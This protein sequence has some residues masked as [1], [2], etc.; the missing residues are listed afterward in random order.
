MSHD[1][2]QHRDETVTWTPNGGPKASVPSPRLPPRW[3]A[4]RR[5]GVGGQAEVWEAEDRELRERVA[6]KVFR[7]ELSGQAR[8]RLR[9]EV[10]LGR[11]LVHPGLV[12]VFELIEVGPSLAVAMELVGDGESVA[13]VLER[14]G[15]L[16][17]G[18][19]VEIARQVLETLSYVHA[20][21]V[22]HRDVKPSNLLV[23]G[24]GRVRL[25]DLGLARRLE[26]E[27]EV[28]RTAMAVGTPH[29]M[30][31]EQV[32]G[33]RATAATDLYALGVTLY[34]MVTGRTP[35][36]SDSAFEVASQHLKARPEDPRR[37]RADCP[38]WLARFVLRLLEKRPEDRYA[39]AGSALAALER[40][41][42]RRSP[43]G[44][45]RLAMMATTVVVLAGVTLS[46]RVASQRLRR[47]DSVRVEAVGNS[48]QGLDERGR[49]T[50]RVD[51]PGSLVRLDEFDLDGDGIDEYVAVS[52]SPATDARRDTTVEIVVLQRDGAVVSRVRVVD[53]LQSWPFP[54]PRSMTATVDAVDLGSDGELELVARLS[55]DSFYPATV[56]VFWPRERVWE[57][58]LHNS[59]RITHVAA[60]PGVE[61]PLLRIAGVN[62]RLGMLPF[63][64]EVALHRPGSLESRRRLDVLFSPD[65]GLLEAAG[66][67]W[68][69]Y[70]LLPEGQVPLSLEIGGDLSSTVSV[71]GWS[72]RLDRWGNPAPG[73]NQ[74]L[75]LADERRA[76]SDGLHHLKLENQ[77]LT[78]QG[79]RMRV[80]EVRSAAPR[81]LR[82]P[83]F[84]AVLGLLAARALARVGD[85]PGAIE[86]LET[87][88]SHAPLEDIAYRAAHFD[89][90]AGNLE[91]AVAR[92]ERII[93]APRTFRRFDALLLLVELA[94]AQRDEARLTTALRVLVPG[95]RTGWREDVV[96][97]ALRARAHLWWDQAVQ[98]DTA[99]VSS[100]FAP[101]GEAIACLARWRLGRSLP[102]DV[103]AM[104]RFVDGNPD[105]AWAGRLALAAAE[106]GAG[107][108]VAAAE[109]LG[110]AVA[111]LEPVSRDDFANRQLL[112]LARGLRVKALLASGDHAAA[113][114]EARR[115]RPTLRAGLLPAILVD[116]VLRDAGSPAR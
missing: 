83:P 71:S 70:Q 61:Q 48:I 88:R 97:P 104:R 19:V 116:E 25:A 109:A 36:H 23:E 37:H 60:V 74:G 59:G 84:A 52:S 11:S 22:V 56:A 16:P 78:P 91:G 87:T 5:L 94:I 64:A 44:R 1:S 10:R 45:R 27:V 42:V 101:E 17:I 102:G 39:D 81:L 6:V 50:W 31:P 100:N 66:A 93:D 82:E 77:A 85:L 43:R 68:I 26:D 108:A 8:E 4:V 51:L 65:M 111:D 33:E 18:R 57:T 28:T 29:Y 21:E 58:V 34:Q 15:A 3:E 41:S 54:Y 14:E 86:M 12:R 63:A 62:N 40:R 99:V 75:D 38:V 103:E 92:L 115:V 112:D 96:K 105:A 7:S 55:H 107:R 32:R 72:V 47:G 13:A 20:Q 9:R 90:L 67:A 30:A 114:A 73:P 110:V 80:E 95:P 98:D 106:L 76:F 53:L 113:L 24:G 89:A 69:W 79:V 35:F 2:E 49:V 46:A